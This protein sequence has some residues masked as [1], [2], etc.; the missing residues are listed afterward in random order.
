MR[1]VGEP[2]LASDVISDGALAFLAQLHARFDYRRTSLLTRREA[3]Q[4]RL[5]AG[6]KPSSCP[7]TRHI[8]ESDWRVAQI[9][10]EL[11]DRRVEITGPVDRKM[12]INALNSGAKVFM[13][14]FEDSHSPTWR[15][16]LQGQIN[17]SDAITRTITYTSPEGKAYALCDTP[18]ILMVRPRGWHLSEKHVLADGQPMSAALVDFGLFLY[19]NFTLLAERGERPL[20]YLPKLENAVEA[21]LWNDILTFSEQHLGMP[22]G[23]I[24]CTVLIETIL[25]A[26][27]MEEILFQLRD[28][29]LA[30]NC[31][32]WDYIFSFIK[33]LGT[34]DDCLLPDRSQLTMDKAFLRAYSLRLIQVCHKRGAL[35][36][37][38]MAA[39]IPIK[40]DAKANEAVLAKVRAD[41]E[42]EASDGHDGTWVAH[43]ALVPI[44]MDV[45]DR[46]M[47]TVNQVYRLREDVKISASDL[48]RVHEGTITLEGIRTNAAVALRYIESWLRG[49]GCV[50]IFNLMEDAATAEICRAQLWQ[51]MRHEQAR[52][53][54]GERITPKLITSAIE[55]E[56]ASLRTSLGE[57]YATTRFDQAHALLTSLLASDDF[58]P[59]LTIPASDLID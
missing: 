43:P 12:V 52:L 54:T 32:R 46:L 57:T 22:V 29:I 2:A 50:P 25:A 48:L 10:P 16:T 33:K 30:L 1:L 40:G 6:E 55:S 18:A 53:A 36:M 58:V 42:R 35:A 4:E 8:R 28:H 34:H 56:L 24:R 26:F 39:F 20:F 23:T 15:G 27:E 21:R 59:F 44:A 47:P 7:H 45:F 5:L 38:G 17:L 3:V 31:G 51:W 49:Q 11:Q 41:K 14:D 19:R 37:G 9:P 13:A